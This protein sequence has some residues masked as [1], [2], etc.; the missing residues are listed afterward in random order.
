VSGVSAQVDGDV[1]RHVRHTSYIRHTS[2]SSGHP[3]PAKSQRT[4]HLHSVRRSGSS[5]P[6]HGGEGLGD[7]D[8]QPHSHAMGQRRA[9]G[10]R[11]FVPGPSGEA[12][13]SPRQGVVTMGR[14][15]RWFCVVV[16]LAVSCLAS[17]LVAPAW[18]CDCGAYV[19]D[20][21]GASAATERALVAW[22]AIAV[23]SPG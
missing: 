16:T 14:A 5:P 18:A 11:V 13:D 3:Y 8:R 6:A 23:T 21:A 20:H 7:S 1:R 10:M 4:A 12:G 2:N 17:G 22:P 9:P 19:P 15:I